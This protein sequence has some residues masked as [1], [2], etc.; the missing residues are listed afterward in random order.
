MNIA[1]I[2]AGG[3]GRRM[4]ANIPKQFIE[5]QDKPIIAHTLEKFE[6][7]RCIDA[8]QIVCVDSYMDYVGKMVEDYGISKVKWI[9]PGGSS[10]IRSVQ[11]G[12]YALSKTCSSDDMVI[13]HMSVAP[14][15]E[16]DIITDSI[17]VCKKNGNAISANSCLLC[18]GELTQPGYSE[19]SIL[20]ETLVG[21]NTPQSFLYNQICDAFRRAD[22]NEMI[23]N[24]EPHVT[25]LM[26][27][28]GIKLYLSK[29]SQH[30]FKITTQEDLDLFEGY[31]C[32]KQLK[33]RKQPMTGS[34]DEERK[35]SK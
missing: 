11:N 8:I 19:R 23:D 34:S 20:R 1:M 14:F 31:L 22:E 2:L 33:S 29:G 30:N 15:I 17:V 25:S 5:I 4:G 6:E 9:V 35:E 13:I 10:F 26:Y 3:N 21:L 24:L 27:E 7:H 32:A 18:M 28:L 12:V 16:A